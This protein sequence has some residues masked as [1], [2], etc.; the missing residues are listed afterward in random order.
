M[1]KIQIIAFTIN[2]VVILG[3][4]IVYMIIARIIV[5]WFTLGNAGPKG[6]IVQILHDATNPFINLARKLPHRI[7]MIDFAPL[8]ALVGIDLLSRL[9]VV[10][11]SN[12]I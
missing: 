4:I 5:S 10:L 1:S 3:N 11:L 2:F 8:I 6:R 7:G 9:I 12:L